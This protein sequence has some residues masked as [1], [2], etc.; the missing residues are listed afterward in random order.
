VDAGAVPDAVAERL[1]PL[2]PRLALVVAEE[3]GDESKAAGER[4][5][6]AGF[7]EVSLLAGAPLPAAKTAA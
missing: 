3:A 1:A 7:A 6:A 4:L 5:R 2:L